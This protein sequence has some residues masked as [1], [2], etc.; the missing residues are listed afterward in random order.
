MLE[1]PWYLGRSLDSDRVVR[2]YLAA[3]T[4][5]T[6]RDFD[7]ELDAATL[8][9]TISQ[10]IEELEAAHGPPAVD[11]FIGERLAAARRLG[12]T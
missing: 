9:I 11:A 2:R 4:T 7:R 6:G 5:E 10:N 12:L 1:G 8:M 3:R